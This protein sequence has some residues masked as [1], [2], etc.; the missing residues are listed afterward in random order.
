MESFKH[1]FIISLAFHEHCCQAIFVPVFRSGNGRLSPKLEKEA[2]ESSTRRRISTLE[3]RYNLVA[4]IVP[5]C[6]FHFLGA[7]AALGI[8]TQNTGENT[9]SSFEGHDR[10]THGRRT[11]AKGWGDS[12]SS[13]FVSL[14]SVS[15]KDAFS[16]DLSAPHHSCGRLHH[17][18]DH[19]GQIMFHL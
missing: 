7:G 5:V 1:G 3:K 11:R 12:P 14:V 2:V 17:R 18:C 8:A 10:G 16:F 19:N 4:Y 9:A 15:M 6:S 13:E